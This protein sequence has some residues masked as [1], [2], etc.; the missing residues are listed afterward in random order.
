MRNCEIYMNVCYWLYPCPFSLKRQQ[1][2]ET[3]KQAPD[4]AQ[5]RQTTEPQTAITRPNTNI[6]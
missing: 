4:K 2:R 1:T 3:N 6:V 5:T